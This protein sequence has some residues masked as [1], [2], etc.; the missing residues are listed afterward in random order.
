MNL[1][2]A[3]PTWWAALPAASRLAV[4]M[5]HIFF[6]MVGIAAFMITVLTILTLYCLIRYR[7]GNQVSR[8]PVQI[9]TW[10]VEV[11]WTTGTTLAFL[12]F[13]YWGA[14]LY[15][16]V[17]RPTLG[18][19][20]LDVVGR[21]WMWDIRHPDGRRE[22]NELHVAVNQPVRLRLSSEDVIHSFFVPALRLKQDVVPGRSIRMNFD[23]DRPGVYAIFCTQYCGT[24]HSE[25]VGTVYAMEP[26]AYAAWVR[27]G[28]SLAPTETF[29]R[30]QSLFIKYGCAGCHT[31]GSTVKAPALQGIYGKTVPLDGGAWAK[32]DDAY[33]RDSILLPA[34]QIAA[35][36]APVMPSFQG[37][38][39]EGDLLELI[40]YIKA[41]APAEPVPLR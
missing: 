6:T 37:V 22:F 31:P 5:D 29:A 30:G 20:E 27:E 34:K 7:A 35:G 1:L 23:V 24:K 40:S 36:Y 9:A 39:P 14:R 25:M 8:A 13:F 26:E 15:L 21:Q 2:A 4:R 38:I 10:K 19:D 17:E 16:D 3:S 11:A 32:V 28:A 12:M 18:A 33:L 41:L